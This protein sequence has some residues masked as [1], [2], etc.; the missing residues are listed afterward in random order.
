MIELAFIR[1][2]L[3]AHARMPFRHVARLRRIE[4]KTEAVA[5]APVLGEHAR[6]EDLFAGRDAD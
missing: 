1:R 2:P 5:D 3:G 4:P 6:D